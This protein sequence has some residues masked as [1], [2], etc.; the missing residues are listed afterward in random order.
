MSF[1]N[2]RRERGKELRERETNGFRSIWRS[3][4]EAK[5]RGATVEQ[6]RRHH[7]PVKHD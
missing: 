1:E 7:E 5:Q 4:A 2:R 6:H 3:R